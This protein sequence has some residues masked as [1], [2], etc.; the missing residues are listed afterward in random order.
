[1]V[2]SSVVCSAA[3]SDNLKVVSLV[4]RMVAEM[5]AWMVAGMDDMS[6]GWMVEHLVELLDDMM[7]VS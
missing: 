5:A 4:V 3:Y 2:E 1:M 6:V 7:V